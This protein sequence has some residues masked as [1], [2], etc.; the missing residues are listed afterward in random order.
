MS[1]R[2]SRR[3][4]PT[5]GRKLRPPHPTSSP[6]R[7]TPPP[8]RR[9]RPSKPIK[10]LR[11]Y[12]SEP[13]LWTVGSLEEHNPRQQTQN[14]F[15]LFRPQTCTDVFTSPLRSLSP[16]SYSFHRYGEDS[17]VVVNVTVE[18]S[19][20]PVRAMVSLGSSVEETI[21]LVVDKYGQEGRSPR[22]DLGAASTF[23]LHH[24]YF[25]LERLNNSDRIGDLGSRSFFLRKSSSRQSS[26]NGDGDA[27]EEV[28]VLNRAPPVVSPQVFFS[29]IIRRFNKIGRRTRKIWKVLGCMSCS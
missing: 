6:H 9:Q 24:S 2:N 25:S 21:K 29:L 10:I 3:R 14:Q 5:H 4:T 11:R 13:I 17:K 27:P 23:E 1:E 20:G 16:S 8:N 26:I 15:F 18:G 22:L 19:P 12:S 28:E 7:P